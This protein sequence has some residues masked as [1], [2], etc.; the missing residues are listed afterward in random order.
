MYRTGTN[1]LRKNGGPPQARE[2]RILKLFSFLTFHFVCG[3]GIILYLVF[4]CFFRIYLFVEGGVKANLFPI[5][6]LPMGWAWWQ[7]GIVKKYW[8]VR[9]E[10]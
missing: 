1:R 10:F 3:L 7:E 5:L 8:E 2:E 6:L 4:L 9:Q